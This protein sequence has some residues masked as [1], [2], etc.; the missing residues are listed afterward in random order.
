MFHLPPNFILLIICFFISLVDIAFK[1]G[2]ITS[3]TYNLLLSEHVIQKWKKKKKTGRP[4]SVYLLLPYQVA[5]VTQWHV[6][7]IYVHYET[8]LFF[9]SSTTQQ[10]YDITPN[11]CVHFATLRALDKKRG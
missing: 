4:L 11:L 1:N 7:Y 10:T 9:F 6:L 3:A 2:Y 8:K 5:R